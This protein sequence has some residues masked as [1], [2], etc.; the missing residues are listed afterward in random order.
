[1]LDLL[2]AGGGPVGLATAL[3]AA[4]AG[5]ST[6]VVEPR[7]GPIDKACGEGLM[8]GA[9]EALNGVGVAL[10]GCPLRGI[11]YTDGRRAAEAAFSAGEG[12]GVRRTALHA[13]LGDAVAKAGVPILAGSVG[14]VEQDA[15]RVAAAGLQARYLAVADGLHSPVRRQLGLATG[16]G[17]SR[18][19][20]W[21]ARPARF[22]LRRHYAVAPWGDFVEVHWG[23][24]LEAYVTP[25]ASDLVG[26]ALLT[27]RRAP[28]ADQ[29]RQFPALRE[30]LP[31]QAVTSTRGAGPLLQR[32][33]ARVAGRV[34][35]VGDAA[36]YVDALT[37][38]GISVG[39]A[40]A[41]ALVACVAADQPND[42][43]RRWLTASR[44]YRWITSSLLAVRAHQRTAG[45]IVPAA[46]RLPGLFA[47]VVNQLAC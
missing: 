23:K 33:R 15:T 9:V 6:A 45:L 17:P 36:G 37:G 19:L 27:S 2:I 1:V 3:Y 30:R 22:G 28:F 26:V 18:R 14:H 21:R 7:T 4:R 39:M 5:L 44:R 32:S 41:R 13:A 35:L 16:G 24:D 42:Y 11:R 38:E 46:V 20:S 8:P 34:L 31:D 29:L 10:R 43:E 12:Y 40:G 25:V 47:A